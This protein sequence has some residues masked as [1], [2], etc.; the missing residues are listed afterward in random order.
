MSRYVIK[1]TMPAFIIAPPEYIG[2]AQTG[3]P[4][5][6]AS[7]A[8]ALAW[9]EANADGATMQEMDCRIVPAPQEVNA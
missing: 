9:W 2:D 7:E 8:E 5:T 1:R 6:F 3:Q 4:M